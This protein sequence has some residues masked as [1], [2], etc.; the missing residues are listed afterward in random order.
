M[1]T[2]ISGFMALVVATAL[3]VVACGKKDEQQPPRP[4][5]PTPVTP[6]P[7]PV[8]IDPQVALRAV[9]GKLYDK[10]VK[11][12]I[13]STDTYSQNL[14]IGGK[15]EEALLTQ[16]PIQAQVPHQQDTAARA[17][18]L[19]E[20]FIRDNCLQSIRSNV[21][22]ADGTSQSSFHIEAQDKAC[23]ANRAL[24]QDTSSIKFVLLDRNF[25]GTSGEPQVNISR[26]LAVPRRV[27]GLR[28][29]ESV[30]SYEWNSISTRHQEQID[31]VLENLCTDRFASIC[32]FHIT[33]GANPRWE[34]LEILYQTPREMPRSR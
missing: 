28:S 10:E 27:L 31:M 13:R 29:F 2:K 20:Q 11:E 18:Q 16:L 1:L 14:K 4:P 26:M 19:F 24:Q 7:T 17:R 9:Y 30:A 8:T 34:K 22:F 21:K 32:K 12:V 3:V 5:G 6:G 33:K 15:L 23:P 25:G